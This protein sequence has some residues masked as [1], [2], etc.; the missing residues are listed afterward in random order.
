MLIST[1]RLTQD[2]LAGV[3]AIVTGAGGGIGYEAARA[4]IWMGARVVVAEIDPVSGDDAQHSLEQEFGPGKAVFIQTDVGDEKSVAHLAR[5][6]GGSSGRVDIVINNATIA[7]LGA[8]V[9]MPIRK[10][11][12]SYRVNLRGPVLLARA[13]LPEMIARRSGVFMCVGSVGVAYMGAYELMKTAQVGLSATLAAELEE[14][15]VSIFTISPGAVPTRTFLGS[16]EELA[17]LYGKTSDEFIAM[18]EQQTLSIEAAGAGFAA[19]AAQARRYHG[20][21]IASIQALIDAGIDSRAPSEVVKKEVPEE[22][23]KPLVEAVRRVRETLDREVSGWKSR[24]VFERQWLVR[25]FKQ[26]A[27]LSPEHWLELLSKAED[28]AARRDSRGLAVLPF[29]PGGAGALAGYYG[30][31]Y[32]AAKGF[33]KDPTARAE[34]LKI[35]EGWRLDA[36]K[37]DELLKGS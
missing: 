25:T 23:F 37:L 16:I 3:T 14:T 27:G 36:E 4:L 18:I 26:K 12:D 30:Y 19:A 31:L 22:A 24:S 8:V 2:S 10:W 9:D 33:V 7:P 29:P 20:Q 15:G 5:T 1:G 34:Q 13:F 35:V 21:E 28:C 17:P 11:D 32:E 6:A